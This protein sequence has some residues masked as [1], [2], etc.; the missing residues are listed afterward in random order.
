MNTG[1]KG[2]KSVGADAVSTR[3]MD[4]SLREALTKIK[5]KVFIM[6]NA[7]ALATN[8]GEG[9][10]KRLIEYAKSNGYSSSFYKTSTM[11]HGVPQHRQ[12]TFYF[13]WKSDIAPVMPWFDREKKNFADYLAEVTD[14]M[15]QQ[16]QIINPKLMQEPWKLFIDHLGLDF[17]E[18]CLG[19]RTPTTFQYVEDV[20]MMEEALDWF[21]E[22][23]NE[24]GVKSAE[25][26]I[27]K[28][29]DGKGVWDGSVHV[30]GEYMNAVV[31]RNAFDTTHPV[32]DRS[33]SLREAMHMMAMP[34]NFEL[35]GGVKNFNHICQNVPVCTAADM[36]AAA[37]QFCAGE[38]EPS[39][40]NDFWQNNMNRTF[41]K[42]K[43]KVEEHSLEEFF[44]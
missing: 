44:A 42:H 12:R 33:L 36:I 24:K 29:A 4:Y 39:G 19:A 31:G 30:F 9:V 23:G 26:A 17:R 41:M 13:A 22:T 5:C 34:H 32:H 38:L 14:D 37:E 16:D 11:M 7:P 10:A 21:R 15:L 35:L 40:H 3:W 6:E 25:H 2:S 20:G 8:K 28:Y 18:A 1:A 27:K 43:P